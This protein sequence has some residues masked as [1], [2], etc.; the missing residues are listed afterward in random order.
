[1]KEYKGYLA[2]DFDAVISTYKRP[3]V[4][5]KL[6]K[7]VKE[8]VD[9]MRYY[10]NKGYYILIFTGRKKTLKMTKWLYKYDVPYHGFNIRPKLYKDAD[11]FKPYYSVIIDDKSVN[12]DFKYNC[13]SKQRLIEDINKILK[14]SRNRD[15]EK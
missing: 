15:V 3:F 13:K 14:V 12:F 4:L 2:F 5:D 1:M 6:G 11:K 7:P 8:V 10:Y 9:T